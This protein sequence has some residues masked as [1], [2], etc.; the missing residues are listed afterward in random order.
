MKSIRAKILFAVLACAVLPLACVSAW[1]MLSVSRA[2][3]RLLYAQL[4]SIA[5]RAAATAQQRWENREAEVTLLADNAPVREALRGEIDSGRSADLE[6]FFNEALKSMPSVSWAVVNDGDGRRRYA[7]GVP[8]SDRRLESGSPTPELIQRRQ[9]VDPST[10]KRLGELQAAIRLDGLLAS[11]SAPTDAGTGFVALHA[12]PNDAWLLPIGTI[13]DSLVRG[14]FTRDGTRW[15]SAKRSLEA[16]SIEVFAAAPA[17]AF[18]KALDRI[19]TAGAIAIALVAIVVVA[20]SVWVTGY[21]TRSLRLL[22]NATDAVARGELDTRVDDS[23]GDEVGRVAR[24]FNQMASRLKEMMHERSQREAVT[25]M[26]EFAA[27]FAHQVRSP[28]TAMRLDLERARR[29]VDQKSEASQMIDRALEQ[30]DRLERTATA[31]LRVARSAANEMMPIDLRRPIDRA[32][33]GLANEAAMRSV[34]CELRNF[35][36]R[37]D[38]VGDEPAL[39]QLFSNILTNA[40]HASPGGGRIVISAER[41][42]NGVLASVADSGKGMSAEEARRAVD[43]FYST[44]PEGTGLGLAIARRIAAAHGTDLKIESELGRGT[45]VSVE[46]RAAGGVASLTSRDVRVSHTS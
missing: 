42:A 40:L 8:V 28:A 20:L 11:T 34:T 33:E 9:I 14:R 2:G 32:I 16:P 35:D 19:T 18:A 24:T 29:H 44:K 12:R 43:P 46:L 45:V 25:A 38:V 37:I 7:F 39:E 23:S 21:L 30:L 36:E 41:T 22:A 26:G 17:V 27:T 1:L 5:S 31:S 15:A 3:E 6:R 10:G 4:D 13:P